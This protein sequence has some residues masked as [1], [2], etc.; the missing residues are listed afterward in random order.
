MML[1][2]GRYRVISLG[3]GIFK[4]QSKA[5]Q[6]KTNKQNKT[7]LRER[8]NRL[9]LAKGRRGGEMDEEDGGTNFQLQSKSWGC[10]VQMGTIINSIV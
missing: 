9:V 7:R 6:N 5:K 2:K 8:E 10:T 3:R 1:V 4:K